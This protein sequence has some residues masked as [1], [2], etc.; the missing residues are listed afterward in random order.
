MVESTFI[1]AMAVFFLHVS[2]NEGMINHWVQKVAFNWPTWLKKIVFDCPICMSPYYGA[3]LL[4]SG[5]L[6]SSGWLQGAV[7]C[8]AAGGIN[9][10]TVRL[11]QSWLPFEEDENDY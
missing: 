6:P 8:A 7:I 9:A 11:T 2:T 5:V 1:I 3:L 10:V 4:W